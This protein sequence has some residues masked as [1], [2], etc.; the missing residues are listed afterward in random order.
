MTGRPRHQSTPD[1]TRRTWRAALSPTNGISAS[2]P[3]GIRRNRHRRLISVADETSTTLKGAHGAR[4]GVSVQGVCLRSWQ[5][6]SPRQNPGRFG[7]ANQRRD[8]CRLPWDRSEMRDRGPTRGLERID[9][10]RRPKR[11][12]R[13]GNH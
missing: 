5:T 1:R 10:T 4:H 8:T 12:Q 7:V 2:I 9:K 3:S 6:Q 11:T 13:S